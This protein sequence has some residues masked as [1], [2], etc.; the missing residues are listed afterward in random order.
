VLKGTVE[1]TDNSGDKQTPNWPTSIFKNT[2][3]Q[4]NKTKMHAASFV[5]GGGEKF[6]S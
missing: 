1:R 4:Q 5:S 6:I 2:W 3:E